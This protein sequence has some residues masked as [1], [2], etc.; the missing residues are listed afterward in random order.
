LFDAI[1]RRRSSRL[2]FDA[3][4]VPIEY[5]V[6]LQEDAA[7]EG[8]HLEVATETFRAAVAEASHEAER[9][10]ITDPALV[11]EVRAWTTERPDESVGIPIESLGPRSFD[12]SAVT[13]DMALGQRIEGRPSAVFES[14]AL[15]VVLMTTGDAR[16]NWLR[17]GV[18]LERVLLDAT[19]RGLSVGLLSHPT[20]FEDL[21]LMLRDPMSPWRHPQMALRIGYGP[22]MPPTPRRAVSDVLVVD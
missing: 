3:T 19:A 5:L 15:L 11:A 2:P 10:Q 4:T 21:R 20:E 12:P 9:L 8:C 18:A 1:P 6:H 13:R 22:P 7:L 16:I 14:G 17:G